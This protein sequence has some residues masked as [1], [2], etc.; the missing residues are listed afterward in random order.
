MTAVTHRQLGVWVTNAQRSPTELTS[1]AG[2]D[3]AL[4]TFAKECF[5]CLTSELSCPLLAAWAF[6]HI[7]AFELTLAWLLVKL[8]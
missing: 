7:I 1:S 4:F 8:S 2:L 3:K 6:L 5:G